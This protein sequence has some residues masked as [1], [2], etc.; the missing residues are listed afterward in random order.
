MKT[1]IELINATINSK[2]TGLN[3][4][5]LDSFKLYS[6]GRTFNEFYFSIISCFIKNN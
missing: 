6:N 1:T 4:W 3:V 2:P 5:I